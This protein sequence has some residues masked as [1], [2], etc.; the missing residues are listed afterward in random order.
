[1][2]YCIII[3]SHGCTLKDDILIV[4]KYIKS[5]DFRTRIGE[6]CYVKNN[7]FDNYNYWIS[8]GFGE[9]PYV[10]RKEKSISLEDNPY[11]NPI[12]EIITEGYIQ[13]MTFSTNPSDTYETMSGGF[14]NRVVL[15]KEDKGMLEIPIEDKL[16]DIINTILLKN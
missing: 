15:L 8:K 7:E 11:N 4:P 13:D 1:M 10:S 2:K 16:S 5:I 6:S 14:L 9:H 12:E 3:D